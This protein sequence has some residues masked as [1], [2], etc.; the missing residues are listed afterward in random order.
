MDSLNQKNSLLKINKSKIFLHSTKDVRTVYMYIIIKA[1]SW[2][3]KSD[4][5]GSFHL[6]EHLM[7]DGSK[8]FPDQKSMEDY[9][10]QFGIS[11]NASTGGERMNFWF[12][13]PDI[14]LDQGLV[15]FEDFIFN[16]LVS[17]DKEERE[18]GVITQEF[19]D[20][21]NNP[22]NRFNQK[23]TE[24]LVGKNHIFAD[25]SL[26]CPDSIKKLEKKIFNR[27]LS[28]FFSATKYVYWNHR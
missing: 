6:L 23:I 16:S 27:Y 2:Y 9:R 12:K 13:F 10:E 3:E 1:G 24:N 26:G 15:F 11:N 4:K 18:L 21:W 14:N 25:N 28:S 22:D 19:N 7:F 5:K 8:K 17:F 20:Y